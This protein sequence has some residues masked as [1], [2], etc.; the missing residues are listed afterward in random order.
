MI[1]D[2]TAVEPREPRSRSECKRALR[3]RRKRAARVKARLSQEERGAAA[4]ARL[5]AMM[6]TPPPSHHCPT[7][8]KVHSSIAGAVF[9][10]KGS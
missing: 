10:C 8:Q 2:D 3:V 5:E 9:C 4:W 7:C 6:R 1:D